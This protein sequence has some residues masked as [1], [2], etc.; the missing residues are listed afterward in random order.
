MWWEF[1]TSLTGQFQ[2]S[3]DTIC[4]ADTKKVRCIQ[5]KKKKGSDGCILVLAAQEGSQIKVP[6]TDKLS[7]NNDHKKLQ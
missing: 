3:L 4:W 1:L 7:T 6:P 2:F 5:G